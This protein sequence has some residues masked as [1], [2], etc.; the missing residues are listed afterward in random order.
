MCAFPCCE[1]NLSVQV[2]GFMGEERM[3]GV[4]VD[5]SQE[6]VTAAPT[7]SEN[8]RRTLIVRQ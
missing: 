4:V 7:V 3:S 5:K 1:C 2:V 8:G 6:C